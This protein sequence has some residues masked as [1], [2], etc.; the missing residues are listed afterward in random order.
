MGPHK[1]NCDDLQDLPFIKIKINPGVMVQ[2]EKREKRAALPDLHFFVI[3]E[4][5]YRWQLEVLNVAQFRKLVAK[6][7]NVH[8]VPFGA[9]DRKFLIISKGVE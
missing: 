3:F 1:V 4:R 7:V 2:L 8:A 5:I 9:D 6:L